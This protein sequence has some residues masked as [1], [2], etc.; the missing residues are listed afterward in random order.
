[1]GQ[2]TAG[3]IHL[4]GNKGPNVGCEWAEFLDALPTGGDG[5]QGCFG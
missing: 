5:L 2:E 3:A 1:M 4:R